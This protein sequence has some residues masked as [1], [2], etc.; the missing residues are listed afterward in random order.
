MLIKGGAALT[1]QHLLGHNGRQTAQE[2]PPPIDHQ[3]LGGGGNK[4]GGGGGGGAIELETIPFGPHLQQSF[5]IPP[6]KPTPFT[7]APPPKTPPQHPINAPQ[8]Y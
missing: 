2:V 7:N 5:Y 6:K 8:C 1:Q 4:L 3:H